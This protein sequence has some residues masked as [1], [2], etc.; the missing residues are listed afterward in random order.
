MVVEGIT[1]F[2]YLSAFSNLF[3][4]AGRPGIDEEL[5]VTPAGGASKVAYVGT[6][7]RG[8]ELGVCVLL[9]SDKEGM[10]AY[11]QL[12][13]Q[14]LLDA[15]YA[16]RLGDVL[17]VTEPIAIEDLLGEEYFLR[18]VNEVYAKELSGK[19]LV[20]KKADRRP[21][22]DRCEEALQ[23]TGIVS[24]NKGRVAKRIMREIGGKQIDEF[25]KETIERF[26][27]LFA[28]IN[29]IVNEWRK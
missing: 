21:L 18:L 8:Q 12:V 29:S 23:K 17:G 7:L 14:W 16:L 2:W 11:E 26:E 13:N 4:A 5:V 24:F 27:K 28:A 20:L 1:D 19:L 15:K 9:D 22:V 10:N 25:P 3:A 6:I